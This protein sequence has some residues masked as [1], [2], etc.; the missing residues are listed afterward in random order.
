MKHLFTPRSQSYTT[1][2]V[3]FLNHTFYGGWCAPLC[4][5]T[6]PDCAVPIRT[7]VPVPGN[8]TC[9]ATVACASN[10][11]AALDAVG[12]G[13]LAVWMRGRN[14]NTGLF[15][16]HVNASAAASDQDFTQAAIGVTG[17]GLV[18][19]CVADALGWLPRA[20]VQRDVIQT[21]Q[22]LAGV[23]PGVNVSRNAN[24]W[25]PTFVHSDTGWALSGGHFATMA[26][27]LNGAGV[28]FAAAYFNGT[29]PG[30]A[31][32][33]QISA[34]ANQVWARVDWTTLL[35]ND[36]QPP[37]VNDT[38]AGIPMLMDDEDG[39]SALRYPLADG[40]YDFDELHYVVWC[41]LVVCLF[42]S[43]SV[44]ARVR[45]CGFV[46]WTDENVSR[47]TWCCVSF[48]QA[49]VP[50]GLRPRVGSMPASG[51][52]AHVGRMVGPNVSPCRWLFG[53]PPAVQLVV[54]LHFAA[55][56]ER[57]AHTGHAVL[58]GAV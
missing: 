9:L 16:D 55:A 27:G 15:L 29:D 35:C 39:C 19:Q 28:L 14:N 36:A 4:A 45:A 30:S 22:T 21:L 44:C 34:L 7:R 49:S 25:M 17:L 33:R 24:G 26:T 37:V 20:A 41:V 50:R 5:P 18:V 2:G 53:V 52:S 1:G 56:R 32:T 12:R 43:V 54:V 3:S 31:A 46:A 13:N 48:V 6:P 8:G 47:F 10:A 38:G 11:S 51:V 23:T 58:R 57:H 42:L 40:F